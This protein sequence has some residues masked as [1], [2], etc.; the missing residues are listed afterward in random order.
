M[1]LVSRFQSSQNQFQLAWKLDENHI[2]HEELREQ[3]VN[4]FFSCKKS[5]MPVE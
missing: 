2:T 1:L 4:A 3:K 5:N